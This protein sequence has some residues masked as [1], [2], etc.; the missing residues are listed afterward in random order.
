MEFIIINKESKAKSQPVDIEW[1]LFGN[2]DLEFDDDTSLPLS[3]FKFYRQDFQ[4]LE[5]V[6]SAEKFINV[7]DQDSHWYC[8][9]KSRKAEFNKMEEEGEGDEWQMF[10]EV[11]GRFRTG[12][13]PVED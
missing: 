3:D 9:P 8:I 5:V 10:N 13:G 6:E 1:F 4:I 11:F 2:E 7:Q 12:G